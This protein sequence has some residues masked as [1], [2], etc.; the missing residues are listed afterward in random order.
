MGDD[1]RAAISLMHGENFMTIFTTLSVV[2]WFSTGTLGIFATL[3]YV[4]TMRVY[5]YTTYWVWRKFPHYRLPYCFVIFA[6]YY[7]EFYYAVWWK[8][9]YGHRK[10]CNIDTHKKKWIY[11]V[12]IFIILYGNNYPPHGEL[13]QIWGGGQNLERPI[14]RKFETSHIEIT[15]GEFY[16]LSNF[17]NLLIFETHNFRNLIFFWVC[18]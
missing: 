10:F 3:V 8:S 7:C 5:Q 14:F 13:K 11:C 1:A 6:I 9:P 15:K 16:K 4:F 17:K 18:Q 12:A 2:I